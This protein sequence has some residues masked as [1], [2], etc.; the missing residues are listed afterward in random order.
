MRDGKIIDFSKGVLD[1]EIDESSIYRL[2]NNEEQSGWRIHETPTLSK[3]TSQHGI[4]K[5]PVDL[6]MNIQNMQSATTNETLFRSNYKN[7]SPQKLYAFNANDARLG[8]KVNGSNIMMIQNF[9][10]DHTD[11]PIDF[12]RDLEFNHDQSPDDQDESDQMQNK[13]ELS[14]SQVFPDSS[15]GRKMVNSEST[16][17]HLSQSK[18]R[19][20]NQKRKLIAVAANNQTGQSTNNSSQRQKHRK[21]QKPPRATDER[22][23]I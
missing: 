5:T 21:S 1:F 9:D 4:V 13:D 22:P 17:I 14:V 8:A 19:S 7:Q 23:P 18:K 16:N 11:E 6:S 12:E 15:P 3:Q 20:K 10:P 2:Y